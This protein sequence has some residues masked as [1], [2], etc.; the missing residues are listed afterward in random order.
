MA[1][2]PTPPG[3]L[4][5]E[6]FDQIQAAG[7]PAAAP[8]ELQSFYLAHVNQYNAFRSTHPRE[9]DREAMAKRLSALDDLAL[10]PDATAK[11]MQLDSILTAP[12]D[13]QAAAKDA[14]L[15]DAHI[16]ERLRR[17]T[18]ISGSVWDA[19][20]PPDQLAVDRDAARD[21]LAVEVFGET[22][23]RGSDAAVAAKLREAAQGRRNMAWLVGG[24]DGTDEQSR[25]I[26]EASMA[27]WATRAGLAG[28]SATAAFAAWKEQAKASP[29]WTAEADSREMWPAFAQ[30]YQDARAS[31]EPLR[32]KVTSVF[33][34]LLALSQSDQSAAMALPDFL[35]AVAPIEDMD[36]AT[37]RQVVLPMIRAMAETR[38][39]Q[40]GR[41]MWAKI[42]ESFRRPIDRALGSSWDT[43][44]SLLAAAPQQG[45]PQ[46]G[47]QEQ[48]IAEVQAVGRRNVARALLRDITSSAI[49]PILTTAKTKAGKMAEQMVYDVAGSLGFMAMAAIPYAGA[50]LN[51]AGFA[52]DNLANL[53]NQSPNLKPDDARMLAWAAAPVQAGLEKV[54]QLGLMGKLPGFNKALNRLAGPGGNPLARFTLYGAVATGAEYTIEKLQDATPM[55][56]Q[57]ILASMKSDVPTANWDGFERFDLRTLLAVAP[58]AIIGAGVNVARDSAATRALLSNE[59]AMR[60]VGMTEEAIQTVIEAP[61]IAA[62]VDAVREGYASRDPAKEPDVA[63]QDTVAGAVANSEVQAAKQMQDDVEAAGIRTV[64]KVTG[65]GFTIIDNAGTRY[66]AATSEEAAQ[67]VN[68]LANDAAAWDEIAPIAE[69]SD[70][71][72][73]RAAAPTQ[74]SETTIGESRSVA[75]IL[76]EQTAI[77]EDE[78]VPGRERVRARRFVRSLMERVDIYEQMAGKKVD[79]TKIMVAG[80]SEMETRNG[81]ATAVV[82]V[83]RGASPY[84]VL[85]ERVEADVTAM[86]RSGDMTVADTA[87]M[88]RDVEARTGEQF[89]AGYT[90]GADAAKDALAVKEAISLLTQVYVTGRGI[91]GRQAAAIPQFLRDYRKATRAKLKAA[92]AD[93]A[94]PAVF[95]YLKSR[96]EWMKAVLRQAI[97]LNRAIREARAAGEPLAIDEFL[98]RVTGIAPQVEAAQEVE[99]QAADIYIPPEDEDL[100]PFNLWSF[101]MQEGLAAHKLTPEELEGFRLSTLHNLTLENLRHADKYGALPVPSIAVV[102]VGQS[103]EGFGEITLIGSRALGDPAQV[104]VFDADAYTA[105]FPKAIY[106]KPSYKEWSSLLA[107]IR[108]FDRKFQGSLVAYADQYMQRGAADELMQRV[109]DNWTAAA[110]YLAEEHGMQIEPVRVVYTPTNRWIE[111]REFLDAVDNGALNIAT[112]NEVDRKAFGAILRRVINRYY[113]AIAAGKDAG[114]ARQLVEL[115]RDAT[116]AKWIEEDGQSRTDLWSLIHD[117]QQLGSTIVDQTATEKILRDALAD[118][119]RHTGFQAWAERTFMAPFGEPQMELKGR[120]VPFTLDNIVAS[121]AS[122]DPRGKEIMFGKPLG[123]WRGYSALRFTDVEQMRARAASNIVPKGDTGPAHAE[124]KK[125]V[126]D[127]SAKVSGFYKGQFAMEVFNDAMAVIAKYLR[128]RRTPATFRVALETEGF[129]AV[130]D[131]VVTEGIAAAEKF[132]NAPVPYFEAKPQ[133]AV[134][135]SEFPAAVV[136]EDTPDEAVKILEGYGVQVV[137]APASGRDDPTLKQRVLSDAIRNS[138]ASFSLT[139]D[140]FDENRDRYLPSDYFEPFQKTPAPEN[141]QTVRTKGDLSAVVIPWGIMYVVRNGVTI[142]AIDGGSVQVAEDEQRKG[143][144]LFLLQAWEAHTGKPMRLGSHTVA[145]RNLFERYWADKAGGASFSLQLD[146]S[147]R[148][149]PDNPVAKTIAGTRAADVFASAKKRFGLTKS[150]YEAGYVLPDGTL[151]DFSGR[152]QADG[153]TQGADLV[154]RSA[155][156]RDYMKDQRGIDHREIEWDE[157]PDYPEA[158]HAMTRFLSLGAIRIDGN[159]GMISMH[160]R[161]K[162]TAAQLSILKA[163]V[164][165]ADGAYVDLEDDLGNRAS[166]SLESG[167]FGKVQQLLTRWAAGETPDYSGPSFSL[168]EEELERLRRDLEDPATESGTPA[169]ITLPATPEILNPQDGDEIDWSGA[170]FSLTTKGNAPI[171]DPDAFPVMNEALAKELAAQTDGISVLH[172]DRMRVGEYLGIPLQGGMGYAAIRENTEKSVVWAVNRPQVALELYDRASKTGG[173]VALVLM[174]EGNLVGNKTFTRVWFEK[175]R[176]N[177]AAKKVTKETALAELNRVRMAQPERSGHT[178]EW[179]TLKQAEADIIAMAQQPRA[180]LYFQRAGQGTYAKLLGKKMV[181]AGLPD[182]LELVKNMEEPAFDGLRSSGI[183]GFIRLYD[184]DPSKPAETAADAGVTPHISYNYIVRGE[185]VARARNIIYINDIRPEHKGKLITQGMSQY[186]VEETLLQSFSLQP[187]TMLDN[188]A[189]QV[190]TTMNRAPQARLEMVGRAKDNLAALKD[191]F[192][193]ARTGGFTPERSVASLQ[194]EQDMRQAV[195]E[196]E[197]LQAAGVSLTS[198]Q[199][200]RIGRADAYRAELAN[201]LAARGVEEKSPQRI[202]KEA[203]FRQ[204]LEREK[205]LAQ[206]DEDYSRS[207]A[208]IYRDFGFWDGTVMT[209]LSRKTKGA[210]TGI[211]MSYRKAQRFAGKGE[212][213]NHGPWDGSEELPRILFSGTTQPDVAAMELFSAHPEVFPAGTTAAD[214]TPDMMW[215]A[216]SREL[217]ENEKLAGVWDDYQKAVRATEQQAKE[218]GDAWVENYRRQ[219]AEARAEAERA[220][221]AYVAEATGNNAQAMAAAAQARQEAAEWRKRADRWQAADW[222]DKAVLTRAMRTLDAILAAFPPDIRGKVGGWLSLARLGSAESMAKEIG[223]RIEMLDRELEKSLRADAIEQIRDLIETAKPKREGGKK[224]TGKIGA[225]AHR[226]FD[227]M[228]SVVDM[229][230][231]E[232]EAMRLALD[233]ELAAATTPEQQADIW[234]K[235]QILDTFGGLEAKDAAGVPLH[236]AADLEAALAQAQQVYITGRNYWRTIEEARLADI[237]AKT[238]ATAAAMPAVKVQALLAQG[239]AAKRISGMLKNTSLSLRSFREILKILLGRGNPL[240][241]QWAD[242]AMDAMHQRTDDMRKLSRRWFDAARKSTKLNRQKTEDAL[243][244][245]ITARTVAVTLRPG[246]P[247]AERIP[248]ERIPNMAALGYNAQEIADAEAAFDA[249]PLDTTKEYVEIERWQPGSEE[250]VELTQAEAIYISMLAAQ[251]QYASPLARAGW[252][253]ET[254]QELEAALSPLAKDMRSFMA[255]EYREGYY[256]LASLFEGMFGVSLPQIENY[257]PGK[258]WSRGAEKAM[259]PT[260]AGLVEGGFRAGFLKN[261]KAHQAAPKV[262]NA[263]EVFFGHANQTAH[264]RAMAPLARELRAV[265]ADPGIKQQITAAHGPEMLATVNRWLESL[266]GN[267]LQVGYSQA[268]QNL[269]SWQATVAL[270]WKVGTLMKQSTAMLGSAFKI[271]LRAYMRGMGRFIRGKLDVQDIWESDMIQRRVESGFSP[272]VRLAVA[273]TMTA[274]P[275]RREHFLRQGMELIGYVDAAFTTISA[276]IAYDYH[277]EQAKAAGLS[278]AAAKRQAMSETQRIVTM[279]AQPVEVTDRSLFEQTGWGKMLLMFGGDSR[280]KASMWVTALAAAIK[281]KATPDDIRVLAISHLIIGPMLQVITSAWMD[282]R[283]DDDDEIFDE[284]NWEAWDMARSVLLG[285]AAGLPLIREI[286]DDFSGDN[287]PLA[288]TGKAAADAVAIVKGPTDSEDEKVEWYGKRIAGVLKGLSAF[289]AVLAGIGDQVFRV[290]DNL[291]ETD[292]EIRAKIQTLQRKLEREKDR[293]EQDALRE[294]ILGLQSKLK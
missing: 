189:T 31:A 75:S 58:L 52:D 224:P 33:E 243:W 214:V 13:Q 21:A 46:P 237:A 263:F 185:P 287:G 122:A 292:D 129:R 91:A 55:W 155:S 202:R 240:A 56:A 167:K 26:N 118:N 153:F 17:R 184:V 29:A 47:M 289:P 236:D 255:D 217:A 70:L 230:A 175:L 293:E 267:G 49:D 138:G 158:W 131:D 87:A 148:I 105:R 74:A 207:L 93:G 11:R 160:S 280:Q 89:L 80:M 69:L 286:V 143:V 228:A 108:P 219:L 231:T 165:S 96:V 284:K 195:R 104:P 294:R 2:I 192:M 273:K 10:D 172:M 204:A 149:T 274:K 170:S 250:P 151:L 166:L 177:I 281:G 200:I 101:S 117:V 150:L 232:V 218:W 242:M 176:R 208:Q 7:G 265:F 283:D 5:D 210:R 44:S 268:Y 53:L 188:L 226:Y 60:A 109:G 145:G 92:E 139:E 125:A 79:L 127:W 197:L 245:L 18:V 66:D 36:T 73:Q 83:G 253:T 203:N 247:V 115:M 196:Q 222:N 272:E 64:R 266:E 42:E 9:K 25:K 239:D 140:Q 171:L 270:A 159:S 241:Q 110:M 278:E 221:N 103:I 54:Q 48:Q 290:S 28:E 198:A 113:D 252:G 190:G 102:P 90:D 194:S 244:N 183:V 223:R 269:L 162:P 146:E 279:T 128:G 76:D 257:A 206:T 45:I 8:P 37:L 16:Q 180:E 124:S 99:Q 30:Q 209:F 126:M 12:P 181:S 262:A 62:K 225:A 112:D 285:P 116:L 85:E 59:D 291:I 61:T 114:R 227:A 258:W 220:G 178:K 40:D 35:E 86:L 78:T 234:E 205:M 100:M 248:I 4:T 77:M 51:A 144:G 27:R 182:P 199:D 235:Q 163:L 233:T 43:L 201:Q 260:Q 264:W 6:E 147:E 1:D 215:D 67:I 276:A 135:L 136:W 212:F 152:S 216:I 211:L 63:W 3:V 261:R 174:E 275:T 249:L 259:D 94:A 82:R 98:Q 120:K 238:A 34:K 173:L 72:D 14:L 95:A 156:G 41:D 23:P 288:A 154:F 251:T 282:W 107:K 254:M 137:R 168:T 187:D 50:V 246:Q 84:V 65:G 106:K 121:M 132:A 111:D 134:R 141:G 229:S 161:A 157:M 38:K 15:V 32:K 88:V 169:E 39:D 123:Y 213:V 24:K 130:P 142:G 20:R 68:R 133:R 191:S 71:L 22:A 186:P 164:I 179:K 97:A 256:P 277:L 119:N 19:G 57:D 271:P 193:R 81:V